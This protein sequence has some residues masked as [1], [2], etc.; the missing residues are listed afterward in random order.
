[1]AKILQ[2]IKM[3]NHEKKEVVLKDRKSENIVYY[4][5]I[6]YLINQAGLYNFYISEVYKCTFNTTYNKYLF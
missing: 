5:V 4:S 2:F 3:L 6:T 1:M